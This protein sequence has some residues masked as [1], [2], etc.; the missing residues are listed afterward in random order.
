MAGTVVSLACW[1]GQSGTTPTQY[2][3]LYTPWG[4]FTSH[5]LLLAEFLAQKRCM[6]KNE[7]A[8]G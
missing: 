8:N 5:Q 6:Q 3:C 7:D 1:S 2:Q 4:F